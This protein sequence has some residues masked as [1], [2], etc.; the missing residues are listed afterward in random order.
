MNNNLKMFYQLKRL[1]KSHII[2][3]LVDFIVGNI[4]Y[5][6]SLIKWFS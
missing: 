5:L 2:L 4:Q 6:Q 3:R 1:V